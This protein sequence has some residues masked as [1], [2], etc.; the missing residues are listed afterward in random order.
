MK[1]SIGIKE[2]DSQRVANILSR[3]AADEQVLYLKTKN[4]HWNVVGP[5]F[6]AIH[7]F[8]QDQYEELD[9]I[10]D[11]TAERIRSI[12]HFPPS[13][14]EDILQL[15]RLSEKRSEGTDSQGFIKDLLADHESIIMLLREHCDSVAE[16]MGDQGSSDFMIALLQQ[17]EKMAWMLRSHLG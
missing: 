11:D 2:N 6:Y 10:I 15:T 9:D 5:D 17:H 13:T 16:E 14:M 12:G 3:L 7:K 4:A 1:P 8:F